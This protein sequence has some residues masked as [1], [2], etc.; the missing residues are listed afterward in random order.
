MLEESGDFVCSFRK[1]DAQ[2]LGKSLAYLLDKF[3]VLTDE[4]HPMHGNAQAC[5][6]C[7]DLLAYGLFKL[8]PCKD[9]VGFEDHVRVL[10]KDP[11]HG[12]LRILTNYS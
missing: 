8:M 2:R 12:V 7:L 9:L 5:G 6:D 4:R 10:L 11:A 1:G 3:H